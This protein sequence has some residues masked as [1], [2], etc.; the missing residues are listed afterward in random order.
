MVKKA[1]LLQNLLSAAGRNAGKCG[2]MW[3][4]SVKNVCF[5]VTPMNVCRCVCG[6]CMYELYWSLGFMCVCLVVVM[7][8]LLLLLLLNAALVE[9]ALLRIH[10]L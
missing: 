4:F 1:A 7:L 3:K 5:I 6:S 9:P 8:G 10:L 2:K